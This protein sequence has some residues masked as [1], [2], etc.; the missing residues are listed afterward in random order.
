MASPLTLSK[1]Q[2]QQ[3]WLDGIDKRNNNSSK[4]HEDNTT[5]L[6]ARTA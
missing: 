1:Q 5:R 3:Q 6:T 4:G 2:D